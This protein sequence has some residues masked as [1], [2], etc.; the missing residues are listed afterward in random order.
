MLFAVQTQADRYPLYLPRRGRG[1]TEVVDEG[2]R[3]RY[4]VSTKSNF[5]LYFY[6]LFSAKSFVYSNN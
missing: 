5:E 3:R 1:T 2:K 6:L 4:C